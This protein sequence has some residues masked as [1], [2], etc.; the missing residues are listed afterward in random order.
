MANIA[1]KTLKQRYLMEKRILCKRGDDS[2]TASAESAVEI[3]LPKFPLPRCL[4]RLNARWDNRFLQRN[5]NLQLCWNIRQ[6]LPRC[7]TE[8]RLLSPLSFH[9]PPLQSFHLLNS[10]SAPQLDF[11]SLNPSCSSDSPA[12]RLLPLY[13]LYWTGTMAPGGKTGNGWTPPG[14]RPVPTN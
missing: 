10:A 11:L 12:S 2:M 3:N 7:V 1:W 8:T 9:Q 14:S 6:V 4:E 13:H 5:I